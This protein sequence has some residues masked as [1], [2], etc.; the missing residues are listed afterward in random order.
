MNEPPPFEIKDYRQPLVTSLGVIL[1]FLIGFLAQWVSEES[2]ALTGASD[3]LVFGGSIAGAAIM[4]RVLFR[5][6]M[7]PDGSEPLV[8]YRRTLRLYV[9]GIATA[10]LSL[11][12]AAF[13]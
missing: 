12:A 6:L 8:F 2:F 1:G 3:W 11:I 4:L 7:P 10:F 13:L 5:M 9:I